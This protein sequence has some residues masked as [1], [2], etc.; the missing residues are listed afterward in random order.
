MS[1]SSPAN[2]IDD[3]NRLYNEG[4][5]AGKGYAIGMGSE[6]INEL[7]QALDAELLLYRDELAVYKKSDGTLVGVGDANGPW[8]VDLS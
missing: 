2:N 7:S 6:N 5:S 4:N 8:A 1:A 3:Y